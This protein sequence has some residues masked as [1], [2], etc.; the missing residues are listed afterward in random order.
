MSITLFTCPIGDSLPVFEDPECP[1][2]YGNVIALALQF[3]QNTPTFTESSIKLS[4]TWTPLLAEEDTTGIRIVQATNF[5]T[6]PGEVISEGGN[7]ATTYKGRRKVKGGGFTEAR[8][9]MQG[10]EPAYAKAAS[11]FTKYSAL[12]NQRTRLRAFF[13]TDEN[14]ILSGSDFNGIEI[15]AWFVQDSAK[16]TGFKVEEIF[17][18]TFGMDY[19]WSFDTMT[20]TLASFD[21]Q[22]LGNA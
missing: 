22:N 1:A 11:A 2:L 17:P 6:T 5:T 20:A 21:V 7:D 10:V 4:A 15:W 12:P 19:G 16:G 8:F 9:E 13:L 14:Y 18:V 3:N